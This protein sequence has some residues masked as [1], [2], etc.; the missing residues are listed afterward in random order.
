MAKFER[1]LRFAYRHRRGPLINRLRKVLE[2]VLGDATSGRKILRG[3]LAGYRLAFNP[4]DSKAV[5]MGLHEP[6]VQEAVSINLSQGQVA[7]DV[8]AHIGYFVLLMARIAGRGGRVVGFE[9]DPQNYE[10]LV[11]NI[12]I[13]GLGDRVVARMQALGATQGRGELEQGWQSSYSKVVAG[14]EGAV[15]VSTLDHAVYE[16]GEPPPDML[17]VDVE[18]G[19]HDVLRGAARFLEERSPVL[20][21]EHHGEAESLTRRLAALGYDV[22]D[23]D[24]SH[25]LFRKPG[26]ATVSGAAG[27]GPGGSAPASYQPETPVLEHPRDSGT[28]GIPRDEVSVQVDPYMSH[29]PHRIPGNG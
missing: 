22:T 17:L 7:W 6:L 23:V 25:M 1:L 10:L 27:V 9:P 13:N 20:I 14:E 11:R 29:A 24:E 28:E 8:G 19:E 12:E 5:W 3:P 18:G 4:K 26:R 16:E 15:A 21:I 2:R